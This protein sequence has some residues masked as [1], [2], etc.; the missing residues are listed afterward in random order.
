MESINCEIIV[1]Q[2]DSLFEI[3]GLVQENIKID[4]SED[5]DFTPLVLILADF[6]DKETEIT[7][8]NNITEELSSKAKLVLGT[9]ENIFESYNSCSIKEEN[10]I[11]EEQLQPSFDEDDDL[12]F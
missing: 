9:L 12:P 11:D 6:I 2:D 10:E 8:K 5:I 3:A 7:I 4:Y 1:N